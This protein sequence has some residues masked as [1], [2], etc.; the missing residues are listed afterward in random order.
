MNEFVSGWAGG[1]QGGD[2]I[3]MCAFGSGILWVGSGGGVCVCGGAGELT[4]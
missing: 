1:K 3:S 4:E 2:S